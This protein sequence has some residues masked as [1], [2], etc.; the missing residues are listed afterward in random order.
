MN[1]T[2]KQKYIC[3]WWNWFI[4]KFFVL[5]QLYKGQ[6]F[7]Y[8]ILNLFS[9]IFKSAVKDNVYLKKDMFTGIFS[10]F[11]KQ[12]NSTVKSF[13]IFFLNYDLFTEDYGFT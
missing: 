12:G 11:L 3:S 7:T 8:E 10:I 1:F 9:E 4:I 13:P 5:K 6:K 2:I